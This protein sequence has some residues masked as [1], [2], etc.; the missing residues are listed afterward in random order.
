MYMAATRTQ[1]KAENPEA[2]TT[3]LSQMLGQ[4]WR[5]L[6][7]EQKKVYEL[8]AQNDK[9]RYEG[10]HAQWLIDSPDEVVAMENQKAQSKKEKKKRS[11]RE[12]GAPKRALTA[13]IFFTN[14]VREET[15][16]LSPSAS[17]SLARQPAHQIPSCAHY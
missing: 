15:K 16:K 11:K 5:E 10:E 2:S 1:V 6:T 4:R 12:E 3:E 14:A 13:Y 7:P 9:V 17:V 8:Q